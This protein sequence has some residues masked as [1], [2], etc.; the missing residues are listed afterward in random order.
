TD[1]ARP[2]FVAPAL[3]AP[4]DGLRM[5]GCLAFD[6]DGKC[7]VG[8]EV[9]PHVWAWDLDREGRP[10]RTLEGH[11]YYVRGLALSPDGSLAVSG[12]Q[13][14]TVRVWDVKSGKEL[15]QLRGPGRD[16]A[17]DVVNG[18]AFSP[19][20]THVLGGTRGGHLWLWDVA[21]KEPPRA[22]GDSRDRFVA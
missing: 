8:R 14:D 9:G 21:G 3:N 18:L 7:L 6:R 2:R 16:K 20:G 11:T 22:F 1:P 12:A 4:G 13:D 5:I 15:R 10:A 17:G 19:E